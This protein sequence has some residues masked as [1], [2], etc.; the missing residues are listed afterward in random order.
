M[1]FAASML[2]STLRSGSVVKALRNASWLHT[3]I[4]EMTVDTVLLFFLVL[5]VLL[6]L[7]LWMEFPRRRRTED[8]L[9]K[10]NSLQR[11]IARSSAR[12]VSMTST[13]IAAGLHAELGGIRE[14]LGVDRICWYQQSLDGTRFTRLQTA[15]S[16]PEVPGRETFSSIEHPWLA[17]S[18][19][20]GV[21]LLIRSLGDMPAGSELENMEPSGIRSFAL[22]PSIG[23]TGTANAMMLT[24]FTKE[25]DW[26]AEVVAQLSVLASVFANAHARKLAQEA[27]TE[28]ELKF[29][30]LFE[31]A[32]IGCCLLDRE[33]RFCTVNTAFARMLGYSHE[34]LLHKGFWEITAPEDLARSL[35]SFQEL[36]SGVR[37]FFQME[38][39]YLKKDGAVI[40]GRLTVSIQGAR[41]AD[42]QFVLAMIEDVTEAIR[43][44]EQ[45]EQSRRRLIMALEASR[46]TAWEYDPATEKIAWV[47]R[48]TLRETGGHPAGPVPFAD[49]LKHVHPEERT[50]LLEL[51][52][53]II[54]EGGAFSAE[55][56]MFARNGAI[57]WML[58]KGEFLRK[59]GDSGP[60]KIA[61]V[62]LDVSELKRTQV[63][64]QQLAKRLMEA[65]E[66]ERRRISRELHDDIGQRVALLGI[67][68]D[69]VRQL[70]Q[71][72]EPLRERVERAQLATGELGT[73]L[74]QLSH[75]LHSSKLKYLGLPAALRE[76]C[77]R[78]AEKHSLAIQLQCNEQKLSLP[79][80]EALALFRVAQEALNNVVRHSRATSVRVTLSHTPNEL[81][82]LVCDD[83][84]GFDPA[85]KTSG[86]GLIGMRERM[87]AILGDFQTISAAGAGTEIHATVAFPV[88]L[89]ESSPV[90]QMRAGSVQ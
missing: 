2:I 37:D 43:A 81:R 82:L 74:H 16:A 7:W 31:E 9:R 76:L 83:G 13:E 62:T 87:R 27:G 15:S 69:L 46:M 88:P 90:K 57:R 25:I 21:P 36:I 30:H 35:V 20:Q 59:D 24:S 58:G 12:I 44:R 56:R 75:A 68:L 85:S 38:K 41:A 14:M 51:T 50:M 3:S 52:N 55:F 45:L 29:R 34:E 72:Q 28:S 42:G 11:A 53:R 60:G 70:L 89:R 64:L 71:E 6:L 40:W 66:E 79:E 8:A 1:L 39:R 67:E 84:C 5:E 19:L 78:M 65:Q 54:N 48:N 23:G 86:I 17:N 4:R 32:P 80:E 26:D 10:I 61:G 77:T 73:D 47:D 63:E 33:G 22:V 18:I 49:V